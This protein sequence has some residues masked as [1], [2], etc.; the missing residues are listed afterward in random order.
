VSQCCKHFLVDV[1]NNFFLCCT[2]CFLDVSLTNFR[3]TVLLT[4][5]GFLVGMLHETSPFV[6]M[7]MFSVGLDT[8]DACLS[9]YVA[10]V[11]M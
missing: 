11:K 10:K 5:M 4:N 8:Y 9:F 2:R 1:A 3:V 6:A 7:L